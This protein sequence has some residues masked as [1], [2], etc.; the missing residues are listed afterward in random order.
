MI[1]C[2]TKASWRQPNIVQA[3]LYHL[4]CAQYPT[5]ANKDEIMKRFDL[6]HAEFARLQQ[7]VPETMLHDKGN[8]HKTRSGKI[9]CHN[10]KGHCTKNFPKPYDPDKNVAT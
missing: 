7:I 9:W 8:E 2:S 4:V 5:N 10:D 6:T 3:S 1:L